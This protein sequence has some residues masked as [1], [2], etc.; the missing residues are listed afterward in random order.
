[1]SKKLDIDR[2]GAALKQAASSALTGPKE[3]RAGR[4][5][6]A[7]KTGKSEPVARPKS[8]TQRT[9]NPKHK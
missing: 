7:T 1:M 3:I 6:H 8:D 9:A 2:V 4:F 5:V